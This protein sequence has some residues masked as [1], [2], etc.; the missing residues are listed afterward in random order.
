L[1]CDDPSVCCVKSYLRQR[2]H[3]PGSSGEAQE[4]RRAIVMNM[5]NEGLSRET[6]CRILKITDSE[7]VAMLA[8]DSTYPAE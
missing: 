4:E 8:Q 1:H 5:I 2:C 6:I 3:S 7:L